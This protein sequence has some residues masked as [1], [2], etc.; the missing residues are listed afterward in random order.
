MTPSPKRRYR[1]EFL[2]GV[3]AEPTLSFGGNHEH[4][5][6]KTGLA[7]YGPYC[8][9]GLTRPALSSMIVGAVGP[10][11]MI[12]DAVAW[13]DACKGV[14]TNTGEQ[15]YLYPHFPGCRPSDAPYFCELITQPQWHD[16]IRDADLKRA[17]ANPIF[18]E[19]L[20]AVIDLYVAGIETLS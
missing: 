3:I 11:A 18:E 15:P 6:P 17:V 10:P 16:T 13:L 19:R 4:V 14:I 2:S 20:A 9:P 12:A 5:D 7:L 1:P 8:S